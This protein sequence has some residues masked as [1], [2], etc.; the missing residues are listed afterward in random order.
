MKVWDRNVSVRIADLIVAGDKSSL[1]PLI[2]PKETKLSGVTYSSAITIT[3][4]VPA[5]YKLTEEDIE[6]EKDPGFSITFGSDEIVVTNTKHVQWTIDNCSYDLLTKNQ[7]IDVDLLIE[8]A[9][10]M[11]D[12]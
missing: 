11:K 2:N 9:E 10:N 6:M 1:D 4:F 3:K 7:N 8:I 5:D 12:K